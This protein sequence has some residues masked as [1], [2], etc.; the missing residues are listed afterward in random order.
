MQILVNNNGEV[1]NV[2]EDSG[3]ANEDAGITCINEYA[4]RANFI[5]K[6][7]NS[8]PYS[9]LATV[10]LGYDSIKSV[11]QEICSDTKSVENIENGLSDLF[12]NKSAEKTINLD[13]Y[14]I[15]LKIK[16]TS[17]YKGAGGYFDIESGYAI[18]GKQ[19][20][21]L[22][23]SD[24]TPIKIYK[25]SNADPKNHR[26]IVDKYAV[27]T[28]KFKDITKL[29][30][31]I[32]ISTDNADLT[33]FNKSDANYQYTNLYFTRLHFFSKDIDKTIAADSEY[34]YACINLKEVEDRVLPIT[35]YD[36]I[37]AKEKIIFIPSN[38]K[39]IEDL[40]SN[41]FK[42]Y[43]DSV[44]AN[45]P[46]EKD[47]QIYKNTILARSGSTN[48]E[49]TFTD[50]IV[51]NLYAYYGYEL[52]WPKLLKSRYRH[53]VF[54][55]ELYT[56]NLNIYGYTQANN[57]TSISQLSI[58]NLKIGTKLSDCITKVK[59]A[60]SDQVPIVSY[61][62]DEY[63]FAAYKKEDYDSGNKEN[64]ITDLDKEIEFENAVIIPENVVFHSLLV[65]PDYTKSKST[66]GVRYTDGLTTSVNDLLKLDNGYFAGKNMH[67]NKLT[68]RTNLRALLCYY[69]QNTNKYQ[70]SYVTKYTSGIYGISAQQLANYA[71]DNVTIYEI[72][73]SIMFKEITDFDSPIGY[74]RFTLCSDDD[75]NKNNPSSNYKQ[76]ELYLYITQKEARKVT[77]YA[78]AKANTSTAYFLVEGLSIKSCMLD[79][80]N[81]YST[82]KGTPW[83][84]DLL[85]AAASDYDSTTMN[86][87]GLTAKAYK[88]NGTYD[89][90]SDFSHVV[91]SDYSY[92]VIES[93]S[94]ENKTFY[95]YSSPNKIKTTVAYSMN[96]DTLGTD[97]RTINNGN[98]ETVRYDIDSN[99]SDGYRATGKYY[100]IGNVTGTRFEENE[101]PTEDVTVYAYTESY[102]EA[103][104][105]TVVSYS[106]TGWTPHESSI[107]LTITTANSS[108]GNIGN[109]IMDYIIDN[110]QADSWTPYCLDG[111]K[112]ASVTA[113]NYN[114]NSNNLDIQGFYT[115]GSTDKILHLIS[116][117]LTGIAEDGTTTDYTSKIRYTVGS[118]LLSG[119]QYPSRMKIISDD[120]KYNTADY[121]CHK[122][123]RPDCTSTDN[124]DG[125]FNNKLNMA[126][127]I[128][129]TTFPVG[130]KFELKVK[131]EVATTKSVIS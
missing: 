81:E 69:A 27:C 92:Y 55:T 11:R 35:T 64:K 70:E 73:K 131:Y 97:I 10:F 102:A 5:N 82:N 108:N 76:N 51:G 119:G 89:T 14:N 19:A 58:T 9:G 80:T 128:G 125:S 111:S 36:D 79:A 83:S 1:R 130:Y 103:N 52:K 116:A 21:A 26:Y 118:N 49:M 15:V 39:T 31:F 91:S 29:F 87:S 37:N 6:K 4:P 110:A 57:G 59:S 61:K 86:L 8:L 122:Y 30:N 48:T 22:V 43:V 53:L 127:Y 96:S 112:T 109:I 99:I 72:P 32:N 90:I 56:P 66:G 38:T 101:C 107:T 98:T 126:F 113:H 47:Y 54:K 77:A 75:I 114:T 104:G 44:I 74:A 78:G 65:L 2:Q 100:A 67:T 117:T 18:N 3:I 84:Q 95:M 16:T 33:L 50:K 13:N 23:G 85:K 42:D 7:L 20:S 46:K 24:I 68:V 121:F 123:S 71:R 17:S 60:Y 115:H 34:I 88:S 106:T 120:Y 41:E 105:G 129:S 94:T 45:N 124:D 62:Y 28:S 63:T 93:I 40:A 12:C 25:N